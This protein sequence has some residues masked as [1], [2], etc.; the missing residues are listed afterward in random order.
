MRCVFGS[1]LAVLKCAIFH[2]YTYPHKHGHKYICVCCVCI[3]T[4]IYYI[5]I[6]I[7]IYI[8]IYIYLCIYIYVCIYIYIYI[9]IHNLIVSLYLLWDY[10]T[11]INIVGTKSR[12]FTFFKFEFDFE[13]VFMNRVSSSSRYSAVM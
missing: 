5:Y 9:H 10:P 3:Y 6:Y 11:I 8:Y 13:L 7:D 4:Y 1:F 2:Y 12:Y